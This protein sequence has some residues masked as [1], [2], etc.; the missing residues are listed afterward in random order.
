MQAKKS[1]LRWFVFAILLC[2]FL[3]NPVGDTAFAMYADECIKNPEA[4]QDT[5][6]EDAEADN[7]ESAS[8]SVGPLDYIKIFFSLA[9]VLALLIMVMKFLNRKNAKYQNNTLVRNIGGISVG[10]QKSVQLVHIADR[11][12]VVGVGDEVNLLKE[13]EN[14]DEVKQLLAIFDER[15]GI[16]STT[17]Y[18]ADLLN[19]FKQNKTKNKIEETQ[20]FQSMFNERISEI[21]QER[22]EQLDRWK[23]QESDKK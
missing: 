10:A 18:I 5:N 21:K 19:K 7:P 22:S 4:C 13:I 1:L 17:P 14:P 2:S 23:E 3:I 11:V 9:I 16:S 15:Q 20:D 12:F 8:V 6:T